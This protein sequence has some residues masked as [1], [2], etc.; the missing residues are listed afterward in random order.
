M[1]TNMD[2]QAIK[3][4]LTSNEHRLNS[5]IVDVMIPEGKNILEISSILEKYE[6]CSAEDFLKACKTDEF[7]DKYEFLKDIDNAQEREYKLEG[8]LFP[9]T[10]KFYK[11]SD[12]NSV[13]RKLLS[14]GT[15]KLR[16][17]TAITGYNEKVNILQRANDAK[18]S[19]DKLL[20]IASLIQAEAA[21]EADMYNVSSVIHNRLNTQ[22]TGEVSPFEN[23]SVA[24]LGLDSTV[25]YPY[26]NKDKV[27]E[28]IVNSFE[29]SYNT[30]KN[31]WL[32]I[33][34]ICNPGIAAINAALKPNQTQY[35]YF[36]H[37]KDGKS[38][39]A[40][41]NTEH[42]INLRKAGLT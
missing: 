24:F 13:I 21:N 39:Y 15:K 40:K 30:Y 37:S 6:I 25:W 5:D 19:L 32:P 12:V 8:Y 41:T 31:K 20:N 14:N 36:C 35:Y 23:T 42:L 1:K 34:P 33:G 28:D 2:Y 9:D 22:N 17:K 11:Y 27:P 29:S 4:C 10:Y 26:R 3:S 7:D 18:I 16:K 38:Y